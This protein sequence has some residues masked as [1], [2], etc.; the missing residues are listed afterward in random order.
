MKASELAAVV[1]VSVGGVCVTE[2]GTAAT[3]AYVLPSVPTTCALKLNEDV[4]VTAT[5]LP[6]SV[7]VEITAPAAV[8]VGVLHV[9]VNPF[10]NP[11]AMLMLDPAAPLGTF[12]PPNGVAVTVTVAV[13]SD[14]IA[15][16]TGAAASLIPG[17]CTTCNGTVLVSVS[18][19]PLAV[20]VIVAEPTVAVDEAVRVN[21]LVP[22]SDV[23]VTGLLLQAA[24]TPVGKPATLRV[25][26]PL[27]VPFPVSVTTSVTAVP[28]TVESELEAV[29]S[30]SVAGVN[31]TAK[32]S[33]LVA[34]YVLPFVAA[35]LALK[36][37]VDEPA[38]ALELPA[39]DKTH[40][41]T[42]AELIVG[43]PHD[44][45]N[46]LGK[47]ETTPMLDP[48]APLTAFTPPC[49]VAVTVTVAVDSDCT[50][51]DAGDTASTIPGT[52]TTCNVNF[53]L[54]VSP[55]PVAV[56][57]I[58]S[59]VSVAVDVAVRVSVSAFELT[60]LDGVRGF[61]DHA[62]VTPVGNPLTLKLMFP[63]NDPPVAAVRLTVPA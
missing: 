15:I 39:R 58:D 35:T 25:T 26:A 1:I 32:G 2:S 46:P 42:P 44:A 21:V 47:P 29:V 55:F 27:Y 18:P 24:V 36:L 52:C 3:A 51:T 57:V 20:M 16:E 9:P 8:T 61:A 30:V 62:A 4:L 37:S 14:G 40:D 60:L 63:L 38:T 53:W 45:V 54:A 31:D 34:V 19:S 48:T 33:V 17:A 41:T 50:E 6:V 43:E 59:E 10:G 5:G 13:P 23:S 11:E 7:R 56:T 28:C 22:L 12:T 49:G